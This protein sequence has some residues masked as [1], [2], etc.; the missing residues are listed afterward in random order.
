MTSLIIIINIIIIIISG[1]GAPRNINEKEKA[2]QQ[3]RDLIECDLSL[4]LLLPILLFPSNYMM[5]NPG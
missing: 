4:E 1:Q 2:G 3:E 5:I